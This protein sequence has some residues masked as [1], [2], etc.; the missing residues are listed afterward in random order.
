MKQGDKSFFYRNA[1]VCKNKY[2]AMSQYLIEKLKENSFDVQVVDDKDVQIIIISQTDEEKILREAQYTNMRKVYSNGTKQEPEVFLP[3]EVVK[4]E[5]KRNFIYAQKDNFLPDESYDELYGNTKKNDERWGLGLFTESEMLHLE[6]SIL[7]NI[8]IKDSEELIKIAEGTPL[9]KKLGD[10]KN[11]MLKEKSLYHIL[12]KFKVIKEHFPIHISDFR[13]KILKDTLLSFRCPY[14]RIRSYFNDTIAIYY[15]WVY[16][17]TRFLLIP[18]VTV[19]FLSFLYHVFPDRSKLLL[20]LYSI[21]LAIWTQLFVIYWN[22]KCSELSIEWDNFGEEYDR[23][24]QRREFKGVWRK[25]P[26]TEEYEKYYPDSKRKVTYLVSFLVSLPL[27]LFALMVNVIFLN[28][29]G[30][31]EP[32]LN[33]IFEIEYFA[34]FSNPGR[35]FDG[36]LPNT[37]LGISQVIVINTINKFYRKIAEKT[38]NWENHRV[39]SNHENSLIIKRFVFEFFDC[40]FPL[41]YLAFITRNISALKSQ[42]VK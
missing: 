26:I 11:V 5:K 15:A 7:C 1:L 31:I 18:S 16:H 38:T 6:F 10:L 13:E 17:Y 25:S 40:F 39:K 29:S 4:H 21:I 23:E 12:N 41:F 27:L 32:H 8:Q 19:I 20:T 14:R 2:S 35:F 36:G 9:A 33:S 22:R 34:Q 24:N 37:L 28:L 42:L 30:F 3:K